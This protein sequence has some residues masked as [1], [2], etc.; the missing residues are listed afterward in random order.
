MVVA[1][2]EAYQEKMEAQLRE[3]AVKL[4]VLKAKTGTAGADLRIEYIRQVEM[5]Q[6]RLDVA[7]RKL[8]ELKGGSD[9]AWEDFRMGMDKAWRELKGAVESAFRKLK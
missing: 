5:A 4:E 7:R 6:D 3:W 1:L 8:D 2:R 9:E